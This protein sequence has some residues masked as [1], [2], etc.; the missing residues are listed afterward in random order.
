MLE[1]HNLLIVAKTQTLLSRSASDTCTQ[2]QKHCIKNC[3]RGFKLCVEFSCVWFCNLRQLLWLCRKTKLFDTF[4]SRYLNRNL[5]W[6]RDRF[7]WFF[8]DCYSNKKRH[9]HK[10]AGSGENVNAQL[11]RMLELHDMAQRIK[12]K[13]IHR[14][15]V[16]K[17]QW[18]LKVE[19]VWVKIMSWHVSQDFLNFNRVSYETF[20]HSP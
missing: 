13:N 6:P 17:W 20:L 12:L 14:Q 3:F 1:P 18:I 19:G 8:R 5:E 16:I 2:Y 4:H 10:N 11:Q 7:S 15:F 9:T